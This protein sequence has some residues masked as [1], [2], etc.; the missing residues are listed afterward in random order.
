ML[1]SDGKG[2]FRGKTP[3]KMVIG[4][5]SRSGD[6]IEPLVQPQWFVSCKEMGKKACDAVRSGDLEIIPKIH[7][8]TWF[9]Y[10]LYYDWMCVYCTVISASPPPP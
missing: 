9:K 5:C 6:I 8:K 2:L 1:L 4:V 10:G 7:E 3:N